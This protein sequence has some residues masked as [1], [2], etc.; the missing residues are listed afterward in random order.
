MINLYANDKFKNLGCK[1]DSFKKEW[2]TPKLAQKE[3]EEIKK[4]FF[5]DLIVVE[6]TTNA[7]E[8][9]KGKD[10]GYIHVRMIGGYIVAKAKGRDSG[11]ELMN[12]IA[13]IKGSFKSGGSI[14]N[15]YCDHNDVIV[16][17]EISRNALKYLDKESSEGLYT[18]KII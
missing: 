16:R 13:V 3:F 10:W 9:L 12:D 7:N 6:V 5:D 4:E 17:L 15:Y 8:T 18:Y 1:W 11:A 2:I 14:K